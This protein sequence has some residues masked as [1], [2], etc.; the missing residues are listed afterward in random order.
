MYADPPTESTDNPKRLVW[1]FGAGVH[2]ARNKLTTVERRHD[3]LAILESC[4]V[5]VT[6]R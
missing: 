3:I 1:L 5:T 2:V 6:A 4:E